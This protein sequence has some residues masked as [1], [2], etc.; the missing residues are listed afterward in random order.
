MR[1]NLPIFI[2]TIVLFVTLI[3]AALLGYM[4]AQ[5]FRG[6]LPIDLFTLSVTFVLLAAIAILLYFLFN[7]V[8]DYRQPVRREISRALTEPREKSLEEPFVR[9]RRR[10]QPSLMPPDSQLQNRLIRMLSGDRAAAERLVDHAKQI[11]PNRSED[12]Y[13]LFVIENLE[14]DRR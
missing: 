7:L 11:Y 5:L 9:T 13:W 3:A 10:L 1:F 4:V 14:R 8:N 6:F 2:G 12:W